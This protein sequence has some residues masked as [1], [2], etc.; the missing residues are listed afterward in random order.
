[1]IGAPVIHDLAEDLLVQF[2]HFSISERAAL[3]T[4][5]LAIT[6]AE[7]PAEHRD[8]A[9]KDIDAALTDYIVEFAKP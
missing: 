7:L 4:L 5:M 9:R 2:R 1:M 8:G 3:Y 6:I